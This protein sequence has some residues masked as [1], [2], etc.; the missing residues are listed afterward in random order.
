VTWSDFF[1]ICFLVGFVLSLLSFLAGA[2]HL[3]VHHHGAGH[4]FGHHAAGAG[5]GMAHGAAGHAAP[6]GSAAAGSRLSS[7]GRAGI[8]PINFSTATAFLAWFGG[9]GYLMTRYYGAA[10]LMALAGAVTSGVIGAAVVF[11]FFAK[12]MLPHETHLDPADF[13]M[14]GVLGVVTS[15]IRAD[16]VGEISFSQGGTRRASPARSEGG[17]AIDKGSEVVVSRYERGVAF[18]RRFDELV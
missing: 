7:G 15:T 2:L 10:L 14:V 11:W 17:K 13:D 1:L 6:A 9:V 8:S 18:V 12:V 16:G 3:P 4:M 5:H